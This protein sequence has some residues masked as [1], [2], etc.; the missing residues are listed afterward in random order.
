MDLGKRCLHGA[1]PH[2]DE[3][4]RDGCRPWGKAEPL[5]PFRDVSPELGAEERAFRTGGRAGGRTEDPPSARDGLAVRNQPLLSPRPLSE[6][7]KSS[8]TLAVGVDDPSSPR[9]WARWRAI[10]P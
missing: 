10:C 2:A 1:L 8:G 3:R 6:P 5:G 7:E 4:R 9:R